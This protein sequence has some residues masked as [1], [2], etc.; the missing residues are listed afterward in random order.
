MEVA[1]KVAEIAFLM[2][3]KAK[4]G[5]SPLG[6]TIETAATNLA[7]DEMQHPTQSSELE[8]LHIG[9]QDV[10]LISRDSANGEYCGIEIAPLLEALQKYWPSLS[11]SGSSTCHPF[12]A[13]ELHESLAPRADPN[14]DWHDYKLNHA[15]C[16]HHQGV[17]GGGAGD[18]V[19]HMVVFSDAQLDETSKG[20]DDE[21]EESFT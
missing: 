14:N 13:H 16:K 19:G 12:W 3:S 10:H 6:F 17:V 15:R 1:I 4:L 21:L 11:C 5:L 18:G 20:K 8:E 7:G 9:D 2:Q